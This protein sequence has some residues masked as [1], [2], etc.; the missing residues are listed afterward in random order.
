MRYRHLRKVP[1][2]PVVYAVHTQQED[3]I[4]YA[5]IRESNLPECIASNVPDTFHGHDENFIRQEN[6]SSQN[7]RSYDTISVN[8]KN[9]V[10]IINNPVA[11]RRDWS[12]AIALMMILAGTI[13]LLYC[14][15]VVPYF[16]ILLL[17]IL[18]FELLFAFAGIKLIATGVSIIRNR[19]K[20]PENYKE[21]G[22]Q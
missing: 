7:V 1:A 22:N 19:F 21:K 16:N 18:A 3:S 13:L 11:L 10:P 2:Q 6:Y 12:V 4:A 15:F 5:E 20:R 17:A 8:Q 14:I 9:N